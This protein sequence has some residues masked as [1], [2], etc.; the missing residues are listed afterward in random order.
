[1]E[2]DIYR[3][4]FRLPQSLYEKL[5]TSADSKNV[6]V[7]SELVSRL[8][9]AFVP[10]GMN[11]IAERRKLEILSDYVAWCSQRNIDSG[12]SFR[13][14]AAAYED[15]IVNGEIDHGI[16]LNAAVDQIDPKYLS[17]LYRVWLLE[18]SEKFLEKVD[19]A[20]AVA[21]PTAIAGIYEK[22]NEMAKENEKMQNLLKEYLGFLGENKK[23]PK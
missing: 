15:S 21:P 4:Q 18:S 12:S 6:S 22:I 10:K 19:S 5:K 11:Q 9:E 20:K 13:A 14:Y 1:M 16:D 17:E 23:K 8:E 3:S 2:K 7:N